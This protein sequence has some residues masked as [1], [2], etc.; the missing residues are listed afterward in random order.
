MSPP[1]PSPKIYHITHVANLASISAE[2]MVVSDAAMI[3]R[4]GPP[5]SIGM[6]TIKRRRV[7]DLHVHCHPGTNVGD[8]VPFNFCPRSVMLFVIHRANHQELAYRGGQ[9]PIVH[10]EA[11]LHAVMDWADENNRLWAFSLSNAGAQYTEFRSRREDLSQLDWHA[12]AAIDFR[13]ADVKESK[14]AE[15]LMHQHF[16]FNLVER[17]GVRS[18]EMQRQ[19]ATALDVRKQ[20]VI[21]V[22]PEWYF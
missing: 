15:F 12:I 22:H 5:Q 6:S 7:H 21:E 20:P 11:D 13:A 2:G 3:E 19:V 17:I 18:P 1:P 14:Q 10:L 4:G 16:P 8:Y 9:D